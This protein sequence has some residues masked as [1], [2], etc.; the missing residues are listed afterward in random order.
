MD[1]K[2]LVGAQAPGHKLTNNRLDTAK[3]V[4]VVIDER[5]T[6][7]NDLLQ[8]VR[9][10]AAV[11]RLAAGDDIA[12]I[13]R[14]IQRM[15]GL[16]ELHLVSHGSPGCLY[17][18]NAEL[19]LDTLPLWTSQISRWFD[20]AS[21]SSSLLLYGCNTA[22][23]DAGAE[24]V[25]KLH[26]LAGV[27]IAASTTRTGHGALGGDWQ[28]DMTV[29]Y[30]A[31]HRIPDLAF[32]PAT[33]QAYAGVMVSLELLNPVGV[34]GANVF[35]AQAGDAFRFSDVIEG[36]AAVEVDAL[37]TIVALN[38]G[39]N[40][41]TFDNDNDNPAAFRPF[42]S[43]PEING[44][45]E[46]TVNFRLDFFQ[47]GTNVPVAVE[48]F[49]VTLSDID[50]TASQ[51]EFANLLGFQSFT[52]LGDDDPATGTLITASP[53]PNTP[54]ATRF[55]GAS[56]NVDEFLDEADTQLNTRVA[57]SVQ[58]VNSSTFSFTL[59][60]T[61]PDGL[62]NFG[63]RQFSLSFEE[64]LAAQFNPPQVVTP[65]NTPPTAANDLASTP[66]NTPVI[67]PVLANDSD[68]EDGTPPGGGITQINGVPVAVNQPAALPSGG[69]VTLLPNGTVSYT[70]PAGF[71]GVEQFSY[72]VA[73]SG[74]LAQNANVNVTVGGAANAPPTATNDTAVTTAN[75]P[76]TIG[77]L[78]NDSDLEDGIPAG[79]VTQIDGTPAVVNQPIALTAGGTATLLPDGTISYTPPA[80]FTGVAQFPYTVTD[81]GGL[82]QNATVSVTV[83]NASPVGPDND[84]DGVP[85]AIDLDDDNDGIPDIDELGG[86]PTLDTDGDGIIDSL[87]LDADNDGILDVVEAGHDQADTDGD[88]RLDGP[89][90][91]NGLAD[92]VETTP[93]SGVINY[94]IVDT[95]GDGVRDF[96]DLDS[97][98]D[99]ILDVV[100]GSLLP[101]QLI[102]PNGDGIVGGP[103]LIDTDGDGILDLV[104]PDN[105]TPSAVPDTDGD[106]VPDFRDLDTD[107][108]GINDIV[109]R[110]GNLP[111][112]DGDGR[113]DGPDPDGDGIVAVVDGAEGSFGTGP[114]SVPVP[115]DSNGD[116]TPEF[117]GLPS[118]P[119]GGT[120]FTDIPVPTSGDDV[121]SGFS[122]PD[123]LSGGG[124][125]DLLNGGSDDDLLKGGSGNDLLNGGSGSD[126]LLGGAGNDVLNGGSGDDR[127]VGGAGNDVLNGGRGSDR[128]FGRKGRD[129][130]NGGS[131]SD[132]LVGGGGRDTISGNRGSDLIFGGG[133]RDILTGGQGKD[134]FGYRSLG[135][136][137]DTIT[138]F[139]IVADQ[140]D[141]KALG[142]A[143]LS[144]VSLL[145]RGDN[146]VIRISVGNGTRRL[147]VLKDV[148][149]ITLDDDNFV[150]A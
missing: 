105:G 48:E 128:I 72:T 24:F 53:S 55:I 137:N 120:P 56:Q 146:T 118:G 106:G 16:S 89:F 66:V 97:D 76:V 132:R 73:D 11:L 121:L 108:D 140:I 87:D 12:S 144:E 34:D 13:T 22:A 77:V 122:D 91:P 54:G 147:A 81:S 19:S 74:G 69:T 138:D 83:G 139:N 145:Q 109:E 39:A 82:T 141:V 25:S 57:V 90:G 33:V 2:C 38:N 47:A 124:G 113:V 28:L 148:Q 75:T 78:A 30:S 134:I 131:G 107:N 29:G 149:A 135:E 8:G 18:G 101:G 70:P 42:I 110:G 23:G 85:D 111:D 32:T 119:V 68:P 130:I 117:R 3:S 10:D 94:T 88:G 40:I 43:A 14:A 9:P 143:D 21:T 100:E 115:V 116:G 125:D 123:E 65:N 52:I 104:D 112:A 86:N 36:D 50:G 84:N 17:L 71:T 61:N 7:V 96:Q 6:D 31:S 92:V 136:R 46:A 35:N 114:F 44:A 79:G 129:Q 49:F 5:L 142:I 93:E 20:S 133:G 150:F 41:Q 103:Q 27:A 15:E 4:L 98:N 60:L 67:I 62:A 102:D 80:G 95:D 63:P 64:T 58:Y 99:G 1:G 51:Q 126:R 37:V 45:P 26:D 59:G 127:L